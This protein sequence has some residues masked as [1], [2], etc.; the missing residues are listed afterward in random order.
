M[1][2]R[3][4]LKKREWELKYRRGLPQEIKLRY[5][6][7]DHITKKKLCNYKKKILNRYKL[8]KGCQLCGYKKHF[9]AL[10]FDHIDRSLKIKA[11]SMLIKENNSWKMVKEEI[12]KCMLLC[13]N[14][15]RI[16]TYENKD[17]ENKTN[18]K[19]LQGALV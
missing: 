4:R 13:S 9:S 14:C 7:R 15:H 3:C 5:N 18:N 8:L 17:W 11:I 6:R 1:P 2:F 16:K 12:K 10:E 19:P